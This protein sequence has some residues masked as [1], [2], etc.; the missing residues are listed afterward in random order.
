M[1]FACTAHAAVV[2]RAPRRRAR[3]LCAACRA[4]PPSPRPCLASSAS[5]S[6]LLPRGR[7]P[8]R[9]RAGAA[10]AAPLTQSGGSRL[11]KSTTSRSTH[12]S[13]LRSS[14]R[15]P[16]VL[17]A[18]LPGSRSSAGCQSSGYGRA[19]PFG[20]AERRSLRG[21]WR[22][23]RWLLAP[24]HA[25]MSQGSLARESLPAAG[26]AYA[27]DV[28]RAELR[29]LFRRYG[30]HHCGKRFGQVIADHQPPNKTVYG[31]WQARRFSSQDLRLTRAF[32]CRAGSTA[33]AVAAAAADRVVKDNPVVVRGGAAALRAPGL[34]LTASCPGGWPGARSPQRVQLSE[35]AARPQS[36][37]QATLLPSVQRLLLGAPSLHPSPTCNA[38][39]LIPPAHAAA[40]GCAA[41]RHQEA[42]AA[43]RRRAAVRLRGRAGGPAP[44]HA[45]TGGPRRATR[46]LPR[47]VARGDA[48]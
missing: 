9:W 10:M 37:G 46:H 23:R 17:L 21:A 28:Q 5:A 22:P 34:V 19:L 35:E 26:S 16:S 38:S 3:R 13:A 31:A 29:M 4:S 48:V 20:A 45:A 12:S 11:C 27:T 40:I 32:S 30:C 25:R 24:P 8:P 47:Q 36:Q 41:A 14:W 6:P 44:V 39:A 33:A 43:F 2:L 1:P 7:R 18:H 15:V 42:G